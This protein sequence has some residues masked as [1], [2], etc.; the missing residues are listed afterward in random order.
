MLSAPASA[1]ASK[2]GAVINLSAPVAA[3]ISNKSASAPPTIENVKSSLSTSLAATWASIVV[4]FSSTVTSANAD[5]TGASFDPWIV[6]V[7][8]AST[9]PPSPSSTMYVNVSVAVS[10]SLRLSN[11]VP[12]SYTTCPSTMLTDAPE[13]DNSDTPEMTKL[14]PSK[15][16]SFANKS[17]AAICVA[18]SSA[19]VTASSPAITALFRPSIKIVR[20]SAA[21]YRA[22]TFFK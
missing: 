17:A 2:S 21:K 18:P 1:G 15:S 20:S 13:V 10:P 16:R 19:T 6:I 22:S 5:K 7:T 8:V 4:V 3:S 9:A 14:S 12:G 11:V